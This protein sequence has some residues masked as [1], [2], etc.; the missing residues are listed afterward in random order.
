MAAVNGAHL[1]QHI[2]E[3]SALNLNDQKTGFM[4]MGLYRSGLYTGGRKCLDPLDIVFLI[5]QI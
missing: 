5:R 3:I 1:R 4:V 2:L